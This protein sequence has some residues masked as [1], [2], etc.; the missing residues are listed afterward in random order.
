VPSIENPE[1]NENIEIAWR[2]AN[3]KISL[4]TQQKEGGDGARI[5]IA[6]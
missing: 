1:L 6:G 5:C 3:S 4:L 2:V